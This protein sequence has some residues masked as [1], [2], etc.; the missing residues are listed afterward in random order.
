MYA[1]HYFNNTF[2][3]IASVGKWVIKNMTLQVLVNQKPLQVH[4]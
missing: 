2:M 3:N 4:V 1:L